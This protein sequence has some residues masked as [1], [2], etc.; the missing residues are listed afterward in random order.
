[1]LIEDLEKAVARGSFY[2]RRPGVHRDRRRHRGAAR[3]RPP[4]LP[5]AA[6]A[7]AAGRVHPGRR[8]ATPDRVRPGA[9]LVAEVV[10]DD[11]SDPYV[12]GSAWSG[13]SPG[14]IR[15]D[16]TVHV[17][18]HF[19]SFFGRR[20]VEGHEDHDEDEHIGSL[21]YPVRQAQ[22][23]GPAVVAGDLCAIGKLSRAETGDTLSRND[24]PRVL[25]PWIDARAAAA[26]R[27]RRREQGR[28][29]Q[30]LARRSAGWPPRTRRCGSSTTARP[31]SWCCGC[32]GE[33]HADVLLERLA[34]RYAVTS[35]RAVPGVA[36]RDL[37][38][39]GKGHGRHVK[40]SGGHGQYAV[41]HIEVE[42][43]PGA[44][45][46]SSSTRWSAA[47]CRGSSSPGSRRAC[48]PRWSGGCAPAT[49]WSTS[50]SP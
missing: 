11:A 35:T 41:C 30:A 19:T 50:G 9:P 18:G 20:R 3:P 28:R 32:M 8:A 13:S 21:S 17:S 48:A 34:D 10:Q 6:G 14:T 12:G 26:G 5:V 40:Q 49:R 2:P 4:R 36:A 46:S 27:D 7:P 33:A 38:R 37:R 39:P 43:L 25:K 16:A 44:G 47:R 29:G 15:P 31:T 1:M 42:P 23:P 22:R 45:A 24:E